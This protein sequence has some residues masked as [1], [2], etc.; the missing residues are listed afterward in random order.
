LPRWAQSAVR[1]MFRRAA[2]IVVPGRI[3]RD[4]VVAELQIAPERIL[5]LPNGVPRPELVARE[6]R[7]EGLCRILML[8]RLGPDKGVDEL[9]EALSSE[10]LRALEWRATLAGNGAEP[11]LK[12]AAELGIADRMEFPG[13]VGPQAASEL[14]RNADIVVLPSHF[15][16]MPMSV[17]E[18]MA[19]GVAVVTTPVG[20]TPEI[21]SDGVSGLL[22]PVRDVSALTAA[23]AR[24]IQDTSLRA[25]FGRAGRATFER[26]LDVDRSVRVLAAIYHS[27]L[28]GR[29]V[30]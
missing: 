14:L 15:E 2:Q 16:C 4:S 17:I 29:P 1:R 28:D 24:L 19:Y 22:T 12:R 25:A 20:A 21:V 3:W 23:L 27:I 13:W 6:T 30:S 8:A 10:A 7:R 18:A 9:I 5:I 26:E 11:Y